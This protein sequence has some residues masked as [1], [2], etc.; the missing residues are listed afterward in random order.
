MEESGRGYLSE[1]EA[2]G[3]PATGSAQQ[4]EEPTAPPQPTADDPPAG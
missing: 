1:G 4:I 3:A 2:E